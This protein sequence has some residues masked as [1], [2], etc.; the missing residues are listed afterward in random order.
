MRRPA[1]AAAPTL[2]LV[3]LICGCARSGGGQAQDEVPLPLIPNGQGVMIGA[4]RCDAKG[5]AWLVG[6]PRESIPVPVEP[7]NRRVT[8]ATCPM[9]D[10]YRPERTDI[11]FDA[12]TGL[13]MSVSCG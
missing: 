11:L 2:A 5:L 8:C 3:L 7:G 12:Q 1:A 9:A 10:D 6:K 13:I 4:Q